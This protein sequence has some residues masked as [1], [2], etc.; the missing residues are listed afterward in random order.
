MSLVWS[1]SE[2]EI[3]INFFAKHEGLH[4]KNHPDYNYNS[5]SRLL[6]ELVRQL[7]N[8]SKDKRF[9]VEAVSTHWNEL[10]NVYNQH[11][12]QVQPIKIW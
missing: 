4:N 2:E 1:L 7:N 10:R 9:K 11:K 8:H 3:L 5:K 6:A 12:R